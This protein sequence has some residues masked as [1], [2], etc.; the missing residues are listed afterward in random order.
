MVFRRFNGLGEVLAHWLGCEAW[1]G[2]EITCIYGLAPGIYNRAKAGTVQELFQGG[3][4]V[5]VVRAAGKDVGLEGSVGCT[6]WCGHFCLA[7]CK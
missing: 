1:P 6:G 7:C 5:H 2:S 3:Q 4:R